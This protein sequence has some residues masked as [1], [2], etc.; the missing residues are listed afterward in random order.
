S[1][2]ICFFAV[3]V[4]VG[5]YFDKKRA[6]A[7]GLAI[8][9]VGLGIFIFNNIT[10]I[11]LQNYGL[12]GTLL[13]SSGIVLNL[14]PLGAMVRPL[15][16]R[17][18]QDMGEVQMIACDGET[19][20]T[21]KRLTSSD[22]EE[23][24]LAET[25][26]MNQE[27]TQ[28]VKFVEKPH[29]KSC[30]Q[31][32]VTVLNPRIL[33]NLDMVLLCLIVLIWASQH[34]IIY[35]LPYYAIFLGMSRADGAIF[36]SLIGISW[37]IAKM[38]TGVYSDILHIRTDTIL[39][40]SLGAATISVISFPYCHSYWTIIGCTVCYSLSVGTVLPLRLT[41]I[42]EIFT[43]EYIT[44]GFSTIL[45]FNGIGYT[46]FP[47]IFGKIY[48]VTESFPIVFRTNGAIYFV[49]VVFSLV[50]LVRRIK[51]ERMAKHDKHGNC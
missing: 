47:P 35:Y 45:F 23:P 49:A 14:V 28:E 46:I 17:V 38:M 24:C 10:E 29:L 9:G 27:E 5:Q 26:A 51:R 36:V 13:L 34:T 7:A 50:I 37:I 8:C 16:Y 22:A 41:M 32:C 20:K 15:R 11:L 21:E 4:I 3:N 40:V 44:S 31:K 25:S 30:L 2:G 12:S 33:R 48:D 6:T 19:K 39:F 42:T 1:L 43:V 18:I